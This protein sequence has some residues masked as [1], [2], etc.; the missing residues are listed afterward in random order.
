M[1]QLQ[2]AIPTYLAV[3]APCVGS[4]QNLLV[5]LALQC[6]LVD[7]NYVSIVDRWLRRPTLLVVG[8][9]GSWSREYY[10]RI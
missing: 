9:Q 5:N 2:T 3:T 4:V 1:I 10:F 7:H 6:T 8:G